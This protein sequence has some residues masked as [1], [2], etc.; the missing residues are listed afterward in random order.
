MHCTT[1]I[2]GSLSL[3]RTPCTSE[4]FS[5]I[6]ICVWLRR[7]GGGRVTEYP[8]RIPSHVDLSLCT[9]ALTHPLLNKAPQSV[10]TWCSMSLL[11]RAAFEEIFHRHDL[12]DSGGLDQEE[13]ILL[14]TRCGEDS[15]DAE[16]WQVVKGMHRYCSVPWR[17]PRNWPRGS[18]ACQCV[19]C[20]L[21]LL[22]LLRRWLCVMYICIAHGCWVAACI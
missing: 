16:D 8:G 5:A 10:S 6:Q 1:R 9:Y 3:I 14:H 13:F 17:F 19:Q 2:H 12:N 11:H 7:G 20:A 4:Y 22:V 18:W 15:L 21:Y